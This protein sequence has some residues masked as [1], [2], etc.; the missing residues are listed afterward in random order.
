[1]PPNKKVWIVSASFI[2]MLAIIAC[3]CGSIL[4]TLQTV[5]TQVL[6]PSPTAR[7][8]QT[9]PPV[10]TVPPEPTIPPE[11]TMPPEPPVSA[12]GRWEDP[13]SNAPY[14]VTTIAEQNGEYVVVS[15][16]NS[17]RGDVNELT[18]SKY[19]NGVLT[20]EYCPAGMY[21]ITSE[22]ESVTSN[23]LTAKWYWT[24]SGNGGTTIY[25]RVP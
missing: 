14:S 10:P 17:G 12:V 16:T 13:D 25:R 19:V 2:L 9:V 21:C 6:Q 1:M 11:P 24:D 15:V 3:S 20:W 18:Y 23:S 4:P 7:P 5:A 22:F 8:L